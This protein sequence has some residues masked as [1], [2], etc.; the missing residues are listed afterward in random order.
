MRSGQR[1]SRTEEVSALVSGQVAV[2]WFFGRA[3]GPCNSG[4]L[5]YE[6][7]VQASLGRGFCFRHP[8]PSGE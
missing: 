4:L 8:A 5:N 2:K 7:A 6:G 1:S 3:R